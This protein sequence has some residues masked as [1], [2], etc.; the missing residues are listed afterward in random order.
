MEAKTRAALFNALAW[1]D[2]MKGRAGVDTENVEVGVQCLSY[3]RSLRGRGGFAALEGDDLTARMG[4]RGRQR[5][6]QRGRARR[7]PAAR[8]RGQ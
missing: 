1:I 3:V 2:G 6:V 4:G 7:G 8:A 5:G